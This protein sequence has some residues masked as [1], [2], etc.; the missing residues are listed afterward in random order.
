MGPLKPTNVME[1]SRPLY[2]MTR[3]YGLSPL[4]F[5]RFELINH[6]HIALIIVGYYVMFYLIQ[7]PASVFFEELSIL[8]NTIYFRRIQFLFNLLY[9]PIM[10]IPTVNNAK[11]IEKVLQEIAYFDEEFRH[12]LVEFDFKRS[13]KE[14]IVHLLTVILTSLAF[15]LCDY[16]GY[17]N[18]SRDYT[19]VILWILYEMPDFFNYLV[20][21]FFGII[22]LK[23]RLRFMKINEVVTDLI[24]D[25][26]TL[27]SPPSDIMS[28]LRMKFLKT[29]HTK[30]C[31]TANL[32][33]KA[34]SIQLTAALVSYF[35]FTCCHVYII[36]TKLQ[37]VKDLVD[38]ALSGLWV[39]SNVLKIG[40]LTFICGSTAIQ[41]E[42]TRY[43]LTEKHSM[44][45]EHVK[46]RKELKDF[47]RQIISGSVKFT[48]H[49]FCTINYTTFS[50][51][52]IFWSFFAFL[53]FHFTWIKK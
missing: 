48:A 53:S 52:L 10:I 50:I 14:D 38:V 44:R 4:R 17:L 18:A 21:C 49:N 2:F 9:L 5:S 51:A 34:Y 25:F 30:L 26:T 24:Q 8:T 12:Q 13:M 19:Y 43:L 45:T 11:E 31:N 33:N 37:E 3:L 28:A 40:Y 22:L 15:N 6:L 20:I 46:L 42:L 16:Y 47:S 29:H 39:I 36:S 1:E 7:Q 35:F 23:I 27:S 41:A 32:L